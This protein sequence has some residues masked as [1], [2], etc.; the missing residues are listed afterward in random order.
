MGRGHGVRGLGVFKF[1]A[2]QQS[3]L[4]LFLTSCIPSLALVPN[5]GVLEYRESLKVEIPGG[6]VDVAGGNLVVERADLSLDSL[7]GTLAVGA[8][9]N[10]ANRSWIRSFEMS[11][12]GF[13]F[14]DRSGARHR[15]S[16][17]GDDSPVPGTHWDRVDA[18]RMR[19][20]G[21]LLYTFDPFS[22]RLVAISWGDEPRPALIFFPEVVAGEIRNTMVAQCRNDGQCRLVYS[23][24]YDDRGCVVGL[25]DRAGR[26]ALFE[27]DEW[28]RPVVAKDALDLAEGWPG[29]RYTYR[30]GLLTGVTNSE[31]ETIEYEYLWGRLIA[32]GRPAS[33]EPPM[34]FQYGF[35]GVRDLHYTLFTNARGGQSIYRY[36]GNARLREFESALGDTLIWTWEGFRPLSRTDAFGA[37]THWEYENDELVRVD[38][39]SGN[40]ILREYATRA[41]N[42]NRPLV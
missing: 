8:F 41:E 29:F 9:Y 36:D 37:T 14:V 6:R 33:G 38:L 39:P 11:Y 26:R 23:I 13:V 28:C 18:T 25:E 40:T 42:R 17:L 2:V 27:N 21:G 5:P 35:S 16:E 1:V 19:T 7:F 32:V 12:D 10:S 3:L 30:E 4:L 15:V 34:L 22:H 31:G 24:E 20:R